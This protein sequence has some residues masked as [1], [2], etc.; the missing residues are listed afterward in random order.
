M[1]YIT[2]DFKAQMAAFE[3]SGK[4]QAAHWTDWPHKGMI[5]GF[6]P[7]D[8]T[9]DFD[10][11]IKYYR[12]KLQEEKYYI[13]PGLAVEEYEALA[14]RC[15]YDIPEILKQFWLNS[16]GFLSQWASKVTADLKDSYNL[17]YNIMPM[18]GAFGGEGEIVRSTERNGSDQL[19]INLVINYELFENFME[20]RYKDPS[21]VNLESI[22]E[23]AIILEYVSDDMLRYTLYKLDY[24][25][26]NCAPLY[27]TDGHNGV[28]PL[29][30]TLEDYMEAIL[31]MKG[32]VLGWPELFLQ[33]DNLHESVLKEKKHRLKKA[34]ER[35]E[36]LHLNIDFDKWSSHLG[37]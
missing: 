32:I 23:N 35:N 4:F 26:G 22:M 13:K 11:Q 33:E 28:H 31:D 20:D 3:K 7:F 8:R 21:Q 2:E 37:E 16:D 14:K 34:K 19:L 27:Y 18:V 36:Q 10:D 25:E 30:L 12:K 1:K 17:E 15:P 9:K 29:T 24:K 5:Y 6:F